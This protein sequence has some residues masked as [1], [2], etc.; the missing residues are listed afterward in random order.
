MHPMSKLRAYAQL[1]RLPNLFT[2][3]ADPLAGWL[4]AGQGTPLAPV[5]GAAACLY[6]SGIVF[7]DCFDYAADCRERPE[8]P[9]PRGEISRAFAWTLAVVLMLGGLALAPNLKAATLAGLIL[10]YNGV[11]KWPWV[12]GLCRAFNMTLGMALIVPWP[13]MILGAYVIVLSFIARN[14][15]EQPK[16]RPLVKRLLL[17]IIVLDAAM[18]FAVTGNWQGALAVLSLLVPAWLL[19]RM[20]AMT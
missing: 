4:I 3:V 17:G 9:L 6:V 5:I 2:A 18:V 8:R 20:L 19:S 15:E 7:N 16:L 12:I 1:L 11:R 10:L 14:E 13:P